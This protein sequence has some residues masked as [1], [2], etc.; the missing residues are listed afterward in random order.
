MTTAYSIY[1]PAASFKSHK[2]VSPY[3]SPLPPSPPHKRQNSHVASQL[4]VIASSLDSVRTDVSSNS[5][6][7]IVADQWLVLARIGEGSFGE[8]FEG[9]LSFSLFFSAIRTMMLHHSKPN[10][11]NFVTMQP[12][13]WTLAVIALSRE[14][15][16][17]YLFR[18]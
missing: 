15:L 16:S 11:I 17:M 12:K 1:K 5:R 9:T 14:S 2:S 13:M 10:L 7:V 4:G 6:D 18:N 3:G 8:V